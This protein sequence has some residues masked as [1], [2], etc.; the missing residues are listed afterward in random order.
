[1]WA[2][3]RSDYGRYPGVGLRRL[4][5]ALSAQGFWAVVGFRISHAVFSLP[6]AGGLVAKGAWLPIQKLIECLTGVQIGPGACIGPGLYIGHFGCIVVSGRAVLGANCNLSQGVTVGIAGRGDARGVPVIGDR[7]YV[8][9]GAKVLGKIS[10]GDDVAVGA[11]AVVTHDVRSGVT[12]AGIPAKVI[13]ESGS[14]GF[15]DV[16]E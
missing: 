3:I 5:K 12:V 13:S 11:N 7:V 14:R 16:A 8:G 9:A 2:E 4:A 10:I 1:M 6:G 15:I